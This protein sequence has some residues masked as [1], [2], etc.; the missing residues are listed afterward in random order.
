MFQPFFVSDGLDDTAYKVLFKH[1]VLLPDS[2]CNKALQDGIHQAC[3]GCVDKL[4]MFQD[5]FGTF[6]AS[7]GLNACLK[8]LQPARISRVGLIMMHGYKGLL[9]GRAPVSFDS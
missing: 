7:C 8:H 3:F 4:L 5:Y 1:V 6:F 9:V 2:V